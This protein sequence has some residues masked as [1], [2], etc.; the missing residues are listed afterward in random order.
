MHRISKINLLKFFTISILSILIFFS[1]RVGLIYEKTLSNF[2]SFIIILTILWGVIFFKKKKFIKILFFNLFIIVVLNFFL[3]PIFNKITFD[4]PSRQPNYK[5]EKEYNTKFFEGMLSGKHL[6]SADEKGYRIASFSKGSKVT[7]K[8][9]Y[10]Q[11]D[12]EILRIFSIGASTT[13]G[14]SID[15]YKTWSSLLGKSISNSTEKK[16]EIINAGM[17][18]L[19]SIHHYFSFQR[20]K[21][22]NPDIVIFLTGINDWNHHIVNNHKEYLVPWLEIKFSFENSM[23]HKIFRNINKQIKRKI[24][25]QS[26]PKG[27]TVE[28]ISAEL[29]NEAY[30]SP[31]ID[32]LNIRSK[33]KIFY[34]ESVSQEYF[35]WMNKIFEDCEK[36]KPICIFMDQPVAYQM[37]IT[38]KLK[39]RLW[40]TP[41]NQKY[42]LSLKNLN[43]ISELYNS[44]LKKETSKR[45]LNFSM[46][47]NSFEPNTK[48][49]FDDC[50]FTERGSEK[51]AEVLANY[52]NLNFEDLLIR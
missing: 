10:E 24:L 22:Y 20:I 16:V 1:F 30:L 44:W 46:L 32:S 41:P 40:M 49:F 6:I 52:I 27:D 5:I 29:D 26:K 35:Y 8:I 39:K 28:F 34:P 21:K 31:Q 2:I 17:A 37:Q 42:T 51:V 38:E 3:T 9:D 23:L 43:N 33:K 13:E 45:N 48:Y 36:K 50:H 15:D 14:G 47:S 19:R 12:E 11:K 4:I 25:I 18:G 7:E